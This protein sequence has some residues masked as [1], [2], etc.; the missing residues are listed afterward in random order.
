MPLYFFNLY[1]DLVTFDD[2]GRELPDL[3]AAMQ[4][5]EQGARELLCEQLR[6]G[7]ID[8]SHRIEITDG[9]A[10]LGIVPFDEVVRVHA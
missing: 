4:A 9:K 3:S 1:D 10:V 2:E 6:A 8:L 5:A 7:R